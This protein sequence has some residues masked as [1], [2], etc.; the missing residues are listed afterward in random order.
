MIDLQIHYFMLMDIGV[1]KMQFHQMSIIVITLQNM[2]W[3]L[4]IQVMQIFCWNNN[5]QFIGNIWKIIYFLNC[6]FFNEYTTSFN[7]LSTRA[8]PVYSL[9]FSQWMSYWKIFYLILWKVILKIL[10]LYENV[11]LEVHSH[12]SRY[13]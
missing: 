5:F 10:Q 12:N 7:S 1:V 8:N 11:S 13:Y 3:S 4:L 2:I 9:K 6:V